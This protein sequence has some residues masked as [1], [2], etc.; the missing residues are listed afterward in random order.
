M[1]YQRNMC[2]HRLFSDPI[3]SGLIHVQGGL[4]KVLLDTID[5]VNHPVSGK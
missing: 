5:S 3:R 4:E 1:G 2:M